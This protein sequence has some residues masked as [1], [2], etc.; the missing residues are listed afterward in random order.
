M[1]HDVA[2]G[3]PKA[4]AA[5]NKLRRINSEIEI[6]PVVADVTHHNI[7]EL[8]GDVRCDRRRHRQLRHAIP[9]QRLRGEASQAVGL[10][11][12]HRRRRANDD[13][14][15]RRDAPAWPA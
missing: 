14:S 12:V 4:I 5:A 8:A 13:D 7:A 2:D 6:E 11:R 1:K 9:G 15:A 10:R 3:L